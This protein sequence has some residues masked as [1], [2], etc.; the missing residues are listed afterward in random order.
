M[1]KRTF[2][3]R[4]REYRERTPGKS[5]GNR[6]VP[7]RLHL[8]QNQLAKRAKID[9]SMV[10]FLEK[11]QRLPSRDMVLKLSTALLLSP[12]DTDQLLHA[13]GFATVCDW[14]TRAL[15]AERRL[16]ELGEFQ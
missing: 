15:E 4:L 14:Q 5:N 13:A 9:A 1:I 3:K 8:S 11:D 10:C 12:E 16:R 7:E 2:G 6:F